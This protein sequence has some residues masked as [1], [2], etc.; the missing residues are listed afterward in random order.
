MELVF[1]SHNPDKARE[2]RELLP[3]HISIKTLDE[4][5][6][7]EEIPE[8]C[9]TLEGNALLKAT[10]VLKNYGYACF[11]D[12]TGLEVT[13]L[14]GAPG[15]YSARY[16]GQPKDDTRNIAKLLREMRGHSNR[17]ARFTTVIALCFPEESHLFRGT[18][19]GNITE[20]PL[21]HLGFGYDA[22]FRPEGYQKTFA[23][24]TLGEK[25]QISHRTRAFAELL[26]FL[27]SLPSQK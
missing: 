12:D 11:A 14:G 22:V 4:I 2:I 8:T 17:T 27:E 24:L 10:Y 1:A 5:G 25:N 6:C 18:V 20:V 13:A 19:N 21:G 26:E 16:A 15:V 9:D 3:P 23:E 7:L